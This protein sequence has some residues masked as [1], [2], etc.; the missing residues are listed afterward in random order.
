MC[1]ASILASV[2]F[3][4]IADL[5]ISHNI[6]SIATLSPGTLENFKLLFDICYTLFIISNISTM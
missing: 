4:L 2:E 1:F 5:T 6:A 3:L